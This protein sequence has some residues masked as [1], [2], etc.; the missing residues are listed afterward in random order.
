MASSTQVGHLF[1]QYMRAA[2]K[3]PDVNVREF[4]KRRGREEFRKH[5]NET[6]GTKLKKIIT[7]GEKSIAMIERTSL[8]YGIYAPKHPSVLMK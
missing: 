7:E 3:F 1:R 5:A 6:D 4:L 8:V 2:Q